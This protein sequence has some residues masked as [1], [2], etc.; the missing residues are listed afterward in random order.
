MVQKPRDKA[1]LWILLGLG[2]VEGFVLVDLLSGHGGAL[3]HSFKLC[4][5][6]VHGENV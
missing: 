1:I 4:F 5:Q 2:E 6:F 3:D